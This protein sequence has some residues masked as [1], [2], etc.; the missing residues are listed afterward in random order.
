MKKLVL[1]TAAIALASGAAL[2]QGD[3][4]EI[5]FA[6][7]RVDHSTYDPRVTQSRHEEHVAHG[8]RV[9]V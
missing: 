8:A 5:V 9:C 3:D 7:D 1:L 6:E 2:A 4:I